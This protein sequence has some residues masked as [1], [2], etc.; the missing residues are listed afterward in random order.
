MVAPLRPGALPFPDITN[1]K[2]GTVGGKGPVQPEATGET[3]FTEQLREVLT[4]ANQQQVEAQKVS[5][6]YASGKQ[7]DLHGTMITMTQADIQLR[8]AANVRNRVVEAYREVMR[9]GS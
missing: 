5:D 1:S 9:M 3:S 7:N 6:D 4:E 2:I 8:F